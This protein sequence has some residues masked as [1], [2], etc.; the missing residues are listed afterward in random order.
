MTLRGNSAQTSFYL[1]IDSRPYIYK[2]VSFSRD[3]YP[4]SSATV[5]VRLNAGQVVKVVSQN[6]GTV[7]GVMGYGEVNSWF[8]GHLLYAV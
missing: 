8:C 3:R 1:T 6:T 4:S 7:Y 2:G 5:S